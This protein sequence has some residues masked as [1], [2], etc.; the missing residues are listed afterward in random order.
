VEGF[1]R[2]REVALPPRVHDLRHTF[3]VNTL[4]GWYRDGTDVQA[5]LHSLSTYMGHSQPRSTYL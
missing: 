5:R 2:L 3:A 1:A 4:L